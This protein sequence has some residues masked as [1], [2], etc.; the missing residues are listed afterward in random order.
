M[1]A[2]TSTQGS[3]DSDSRKNPEYEYNCRIYFHRDKASGS[4]KYRIELETIKQFS[5]LNYEISCKAVKSKKNIEIRI[6]GLKAKNDYISH[7]Q[8]ASAYIDFEDLYGEF[9]ISI[10][11]KDGTVNSAVVNF[12]IFKKEIKLL[13]TFNP[14]EKSKKIF[15]TFETDESL[16]SFSNEFIK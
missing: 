8:P 5:T 6:L 16:N 10:I 2:R 12:N 7:V 1:P 11:K 14:D 9:N 13:N 15:C 3:S 4:Q